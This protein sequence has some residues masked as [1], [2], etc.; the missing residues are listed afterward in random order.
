M[1]LL[2]VSDL[3]LSNPTN[4]RAFEAM[5]AHLDDWLIMAGDLADGYRE[6]GQFFEGL[7]ARFRQVVWVPGNHDLWTRPGDREPRGEELYQRL[8]DLARSSGVL[9]PEDSFPVFP[10]PTG[11]LL[12]V[13][14]FLLYDYS[15]RPSD[16]PLASVVQWAREKNNSCAD[17][18][19]LHPDPHPSRQAWCRVLCERALA[20]LEA[21]PVDLP[22]IL[23]NHFPME[24][25]LAVLPRVP[26]FTPWCGTRLT[27]GW[28]RRFNACAVVSGHLHIPGTRWIDGVPFQEV[29]FGY[30][31]QWQRRRRQ[32]ME[33]HL[34]E[35]ALADALTPSTAGGE[36]PS[37]SPECRL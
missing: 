30:P 37:H 32:G 26:R 12:I 4:R 11:D 5:P 16:V 33:G 36:L 2:A 22:K 21:C 7:A 29:S 31:A 25:E 9:T 34:R 20:R 6:A 23:V 28:H 13:P 18:Y 8:V 17:E 10:H 1:R 24:E 19:Y 14:L 15:F 27:K 3:H 35:V